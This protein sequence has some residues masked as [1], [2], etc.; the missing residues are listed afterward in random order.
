[1]FCDQNIASFDCKIVDE[2]NNVVAAGALNAFRPDDIK[3]FMES[4][5]E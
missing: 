2:D 5:N 4:N 1:M 3:Q